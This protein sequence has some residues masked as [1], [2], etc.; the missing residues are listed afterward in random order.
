MQQL[1]H[2]RGK[3]IHATIKAQ[4]PSTMMSGERDQVSVGYL[5][6]SLQNA[7]FSTER[8]RRRRWIAEKPVL[9]MG[10]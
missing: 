6:I 10:Q 1:H 2:I 7:N 5:A 4:Q 3:L 9:G 8:Y